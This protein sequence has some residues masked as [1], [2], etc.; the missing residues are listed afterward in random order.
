MSALV[1][2]TIE[3]EGPALPDLI[4]NSALHGMRCDEAIA[5]TLE[6]LLYLCDWTWNHL[7]IGGGS[8]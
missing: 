8:F 4:P 7:E 5:A 1:M 6:I 2:F 3:D